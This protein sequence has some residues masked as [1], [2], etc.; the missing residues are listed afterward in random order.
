MKYKWS[1]LT[2]VRH[3]ALAVFSGIIITASGMTAAGA[4]QADRIDPDAACSLT[5]T[6]IEYIQIDP[7]TQEQTTVTIDDGEITVYRVADIVS[8]QGSGYIYDLSNE[9]FADVSGLPEDITGSLS[10]DNVVYKNNFRISRILEKE[11]NGKSGIS[12]IIS[13]GKAA[14]TGL[15]PGLYL[16]VYTETSTAENVDDL[17]FNS[18]LVNLPEYYKETGAYEY[19]RVSRPKPVVSGTP[20]EPDDEDEEDNGG[21]GG[22]AKKPKGGGNNN[23]NG[24][25][26][27]TPG[28]GRT[29]S[30][31]P[32]TGQL[33]WPVPVLA[34]IG[35]VLV[36]IGLIRRKRS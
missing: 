32:Q 29:S 17:K 7:D 24:N 20:A 5:I 33:W 21:G 14:F 1:L 22:G 2:L 28:G 36:G 23:N 8:G 26:G 15:S 19:D 35:L 13:D 3:T 16:V 30:S 11:L 25:N 27:N 31:L 10:S 34:L 12:R 18:F 4:G 9:Q 6:P